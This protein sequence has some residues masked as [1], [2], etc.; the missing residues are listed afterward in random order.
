ME[1][2]HGMGGQPLPVPGEG[3]H[4][5]GYLPV[6]VTDWPGRDRARVLDDYPAEFVKLYHGETSGL[7]GLAVGVGHDAHP[8]DQA[9]AQNSQSPMEA[10]GGA[11]MGRSWRERQRLAGQYCS[12]PQRN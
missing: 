7:D 1:A 10:D 4:G 12:R 5:T 9:G 8:L 2:V 11:V 3:P 6:L